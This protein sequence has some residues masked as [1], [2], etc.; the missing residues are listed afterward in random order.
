MLH[1]STETYNNEQVS[2]VFRHN[3]SW[4]TKSFDSV[5]DNK[6]TCIINNYIRPK[7]AIWYRKSLRLIEKIRLL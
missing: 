7:E 5:K 1:I 6:Y 4:N 3:F 2:K